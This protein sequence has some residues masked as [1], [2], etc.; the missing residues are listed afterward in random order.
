MKTFFSHGAA[1]GKG[2]GGV[3]GLIAPWRLLSHI[4]LAALGDAP[5]G[6]LCKAT[7][8]N[9]RSPG[10]L[11]FYRIRGKPPVWAGSMAVCLS[12]LS[13]CPHQYP[14][15][16]CAEVLLDL[17]PSSS[18]LNPMSVQPPL[19]PSLAGDDEHLPEQT[20]TE[21]TPQSSQPLIFQP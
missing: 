1:K 6:C 10:A 11:V 16:Y 17:G 9:L 13:V 21:L 18:C 7:K 4:S 3:G 15:G 12:R 8:G 2:C 19:L 14:C 5:A 20:L